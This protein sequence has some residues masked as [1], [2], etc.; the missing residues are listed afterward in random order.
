MV[1]SFIVS[2]VLALFAGAALPALAQQMPPPPE[3]APEQTN[4][5]GQPLEPG[6]SA[7]SVPDKKMLARAKNWFSALASG[8]ID[9]SQ[10]AT[11]AS[12]NMND[13]TIANAQKMIGALGKPVSFVAQ[14]SG[15]QGN[16]TYGIYLVTFENGKKVDFLF[17]VDSSG[18]VTSL[19]L[20]TPH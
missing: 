17:A 5:Y 1:R 10:L 14:R 11:N 6:S 16:I 20:G 2:I 12:S 18:K 13:A 7:T 4:P 15:S 9:R 8:R 19:G 3:G